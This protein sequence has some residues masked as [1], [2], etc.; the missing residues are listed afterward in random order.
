MLSRTTAVFALL[1]LIL[2]TYLYIYVEIN[3]VRPKGALLF[4]FGVIGVAGIVIGL[5][6]GLVF[7]GI[8]AV[9]TINNKSK[10]T[11]ITI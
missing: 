4:I 9:N 6:S 2:A 10:R 1:N 5:V 11:I 8:G 7:L 3:F